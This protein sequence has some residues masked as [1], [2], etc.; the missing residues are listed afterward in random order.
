MCSSDLEAASFVGHLIECGLLDHE[1][2]RL[3]LIKPLTTHDYLQPGKPEETVRVNAICQLFVAAGSTLVQG[4]L[5]PEDVRVSFEIL[6]IHLPRN[7][8]IAGLSHAKLEV[9][10]ATH[11]NP[12]C[13]NPLTRRPGTSRTPCHVVGAERRGR[14]KGSRRN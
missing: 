2:V 14:T 11:S 9:Q 5:E 10:Y 12:F 1:L 6:E 7:E 8:T 13:R 3:H 4:L